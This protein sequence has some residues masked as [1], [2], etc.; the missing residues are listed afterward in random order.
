MAAY[1]LVAATVAN[2]DPKR[3]VSKSLVASPRKFGR[4]ITVRVIDAVTSNTIAG[5]LLDPGM[6][7]DGGNIIASPQITGTNGEAAI[8]YPG[9]HVSDL[10]LEVEKAGYRSQSMA[11]SSKKVGPAVWQRAI[12]YY[13]LIEGFVPDIVTVA[14]QPTSAPFI[15]PAPVFLRQTPTGRGAP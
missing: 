4:A 11:W 10:F 7:V 3:P 5:A 8:R 2:R 12:E 14:L 6:V 9:L 15:P 1:D 13:Y